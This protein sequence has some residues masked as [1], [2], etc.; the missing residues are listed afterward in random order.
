MIEVTFQRLSHFLPTCVS[1]QWTNDSFDGTSLRAPVYTKGSIY[2]RFLGDI[3]A[4]STVARIRRSPGMSRGTEHGA[5]FQSFHV[6][7]AV[8]RPLVPRPSWFS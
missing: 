5:R 8:C 2:S 3:L 1:F 6:S 4:L 7:P